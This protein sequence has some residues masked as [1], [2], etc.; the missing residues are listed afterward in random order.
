LT[1][2]AIATVHPVTIGLEANDNV[3]IL[4]V[5]LEGQIVRQFV[6]RNT[7]CGVVGNTMTTAVVTSPYELAEIAC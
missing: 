1:V 5:S 7:G 3:G 2:K 6:R 4:C